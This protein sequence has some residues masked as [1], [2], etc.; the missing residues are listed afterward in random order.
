MK[1]NL[2]KTFARHRKLNG[3]FTCSLTDC[4][5]LAADWLPGSV[6]SW[7][8]PCV[9]PAGIVLPRQPP[10]VC[11]S[12]CLVTRSRETLE[13]I[14]KTTQGSMQGWGT[15]NIRNRSA[16][17]NKN[18][19]HLLANIASHNRK[20]FGRGGYLKKKNVKNILK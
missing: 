7:Y 6:L 18:N 19:M 2:T 4:R 16:S 3:N 5:I 20:K 10:V 9:G 13:E 17:A 15:C 8:P 11:F 12:R 14:K 1:H